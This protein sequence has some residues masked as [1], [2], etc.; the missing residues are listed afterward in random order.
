[1]SAGFGPGSCSTLATFSLRRRYC[2]EKR[3]PFLRHVNVVF[4]KVNKIDEHIMAKTSKYITNNN[5]RVHSSMIQSIAM[6]YIQMH[7]K[8][9]AAR[10]HVVCVP[11]RNPN[12]AR[13]CCR[14]GRARIPPSPARSCAYPCASKAAAPGRFPSGK[15]P[16]SRAGPSVASQRLV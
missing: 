4:T 10:N 5:G 13:K 8:T 11:G 14:H 3:N 9:T 16:L 1:M 7:G 6:G 15:A 2:C 12:A